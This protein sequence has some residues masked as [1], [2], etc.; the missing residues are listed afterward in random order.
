MSKKVNLKSK[1]EKVIEKIEH[2]NVTYGLG[3][4]EFDKGFF[5]NLSE[6]WLEEQTNDLDTYNL[7]FNKNDIPINSDEFT[8][9]INKF[10]K[11]LE[12]KELKSL[13]TVK[14]SGSS[15]YG[16]SNFGFGEYVKSKDLK[17]SINSLS[18]KVIKQDVITQLE[19]QEVDTSSLDDYSIHHLYG[20]FENGGFV[21]LKLENNNVE[22]NIN[23]EE[24]HFNKLVDKIRI[25]SL[26]N[27]YMRLKFMNLYRELDTSK[28]KDF[29][30]NQY[31]FYLNEESEYKNNAVG[32]VTNIIFQDNKH[33]NLNPK[34]LDSKVQTNTVIEKIENHSSKFLIV[35]ILL[36]ILILIFK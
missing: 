11:D 28:N 12:S 21:H 25:G 18:K 8:E 33:T 4:W 29:V 7:F 10:K 20:N 27:L 19:L 5:I 24:K 26:S 6:F 35:I 9:S 22:I 15:S 36:L 3:S 32:T 16:F 31:M 13:V 23:L 34:E 2:N 17:F 1:T 14:G 30:H